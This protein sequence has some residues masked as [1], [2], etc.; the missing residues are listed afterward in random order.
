[1][2]VHDPRQQLVAAELLDVLD[3]GVQRLIVL[4]HPAFDGVDELLAA[5]V[6]LQLL[7]AQVA[8]PLLFAKLL[9]TLG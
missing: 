6:A 2:A 8:A 9:V 1:M 5:L 4:L 3:D 7:G